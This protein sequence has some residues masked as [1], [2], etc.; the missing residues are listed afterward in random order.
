MRCGPGAR[1]PGL[2]RSDSGS[3]P[4]KRPCRYAGSKKGGPAGPCFSLCSLRAAAAGASCSSISRTARSVAACS[5]SEQP[6]SRLSAAA[7]C[8]ACSSACAAAP[9]PGGTA[10]ACCSS[11]RSCVATDALSGSR[12]VTSA[13]EP[14]SELTIRCAA[15][16]SRAPSG[17]TAK[18][19][20][21]SSRAVMHA[22]VTERSTTGDTISRTAAVS[23]TGV[24]RASATRV[25]SGRFGAGAILMCCCRPPAAASSAPDRPPDRPPCCA[26]AS[27]REMPWPPE[28]PGPGAPIP[29]L[30]EPIA[31]GS[32]GVPTPVM[33]PRLPPEPAM[34]PSPPR[35]STALFL[36]ATKSGLF[37]RSRRTWCSRYEGF[38]SLISTSRCLKRR[39]ISNLRLSLRSRSL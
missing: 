18:S 17:S 29:G 6:S 19:F 37:T 28:G 38:W 2:G 16:R 24:R 12:H 7:V 13:S 22:M 32:Y 8:T 27:P 30:G 21:T 4:G 3:A 15:L 34:A 1:C 11:A 25:A 5:M 36:S 31:A 20:S 9:S 10:P 26:K 35:L 23:A 33:D 39:S 14:A